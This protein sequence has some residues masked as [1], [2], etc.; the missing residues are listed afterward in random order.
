MMDE[1]SAHFHPKRGRKC[2]GL[3]QH[4]YRMKSNR[5]QYNEIHPSSSDGD[6]GTRHFSPIRTP[7]TRLL[8]SPV[9]PPVRPH[10]HHHH[11]SAAHVHAVNSRG[12]LR[13]IGGAF[14]PSGGGAPPLGQPGYTGRV[15]RQPQMFVQQHQAQP[16]HPPETPGGPAHAYP[17]HAVYGPRTTSGYAP[18]AMQ[19]LAR[20]LRDSG[21]L[22][23]TGMAYGAYERDRDALGHREVTKAQ[24][25]RH[26]ATGYRGAS[27]RDQFY[28]P[29]HPSD[30][31][32][33][34]HY[35]LSGQPAVASF[36]ESLMPASS[37]P[38]GATGSVEL[39]LPPCAYGPLE[40]V[41][42]QVLVTLIRIFASATIWFRPDLSRSQN[43]HST[44]HLAGLTDSC[45]S[46]SQL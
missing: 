23:D 38:L 2:R 25:P 39:R 20:G 34:Q 3:R 1:S 35:L 4:E 12:P 10:H 16:G 6:S 18:P 9:S 40:R 42:E 14:T 46:S 7:S 22:S 43:L 13:Q 24:Q 32:F 45:V 27:F 21:S 11:Y 37:A 44:T 8:R 19:H 26:M 15:H 17:G 36:D 41:P 5:L 31:P 28:T 33:G 30:R 29:G